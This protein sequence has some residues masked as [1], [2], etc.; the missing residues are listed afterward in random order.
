MHMW[1]LAH[2]GQ[3]KDDP[4]VVAV[5]EPASWAVALAIGCIAFFAV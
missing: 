1:L 2:R 4:V 5:K 3:V